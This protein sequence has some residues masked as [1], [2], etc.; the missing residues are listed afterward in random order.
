MSASTGPDPPRG[1][2]IVIPSRCE[3]DGLLYID[4]GETIEGA[5]PGAE[6]IDEPVA[7][8]VVREEVS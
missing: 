1:A 6:T 3:A 4:T 8:P 2:W 5:A 7:R